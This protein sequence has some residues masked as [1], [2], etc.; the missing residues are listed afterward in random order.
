ME[1]YIEK[2]KVQ[3]AEELFAFECS[4]R[5]FFEKMV[6]SRG[7]DYYTYETFQKILYEL[8]KEQIEGIS[9]FHLIRNHEGTIVG[10]INLVDIEKDKELGYLG[11]RVGEEYVGRGIA[12]KGVKILLDEAVNY[13][14]TEIH[15]KTTNNNIASQK[16]LEKNYFS[17]ISIDE[18]AAEL[19][20]QKINFIHYIWRHTN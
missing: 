3:D 10:R 15:A 18:K 8:L 9:Y 16:V 19:Y 20:G 1:I 11:Y 17:R 13:H 2:L 7:D 12:A 14:V 6:P 4:N 5:V